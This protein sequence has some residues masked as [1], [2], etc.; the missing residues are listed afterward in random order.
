MDKVGFHYRADRDHYT[1][2]D[3]GQ[4]LPRLKQLDASWIVLNAPIKRAIPEGFIATLKTESIEPVLHFQITPRELPS[5]DEMILLYENYKKWGVKYVI[6]FDK[7]NQQ[8]SWGSEAWAQSDLTERFLD[9]FLPLAEAAVAAGL[10]P[11]FPPLEPG[12]DYW[13]TIFLRGAL[14]GVKRRA[15]KP[16]LARLMLS[17]YARMNAKP[18]S[19]GG[20]GPQ[21]WPEAQPYHTPESSQDQQGFRIAEWY[22]TLS[23][24][25][26]EKKLPTLILGIQGPAP[27]G[28]DC[29]VNL[30]NC[31]RL[32]A[33]QELEGEDALPEEIIGGA[34]WVL[35][36]EEENSWFSLEGSPKPIVI[37]YTREGESQPEAKSTAD[38]RI[39]HY[40]LLPSFEWGVADWH[41][42][43]TRSFIKRHRPT[44]GFSLAEAFQAEQVTVV[45]GEDQFSETEL[46]QLR[47][48]G[49]L[50]RRIEGDGTKIA[51]LLAAI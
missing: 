47:N 40:L 50:V 43:V 15:S 5:V 26:L 11:V 38:F 9:G 7:P 36:G 49:C 33:R 32:I 1:E 17:A 22:L 4:W 31:A 13:D 28:E 18:L 41:L 44:V 8:E 3:L 29:V 2:R 21:S 12:G 30:I 16:L 23:E 19:W 14:D 10:V 35:A 45:G 51:S 6:L 46:R 48:Q 37:A 24:T 42:N 34:F 39:A 20:G 27:E 25:V